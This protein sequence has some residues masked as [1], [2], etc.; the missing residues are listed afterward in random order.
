MCDSGLKQQ[1]LYIVNEMGTGK[2]E[3]VVTVVLISFPLIV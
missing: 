2:D 3:P 1:S